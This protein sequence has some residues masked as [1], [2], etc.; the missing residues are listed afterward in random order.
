MTTILFRVRPAVL[1]IG[2]FLPGI[3]LAP[4]E[5]RA[6][7]FLFTTAGVSGPYEE[8]CSQTGTNSAACATSGTDPSNSATFGGSATARASFGDLSTFASGIANFMTTQSGTD[9]NSLSFISIPEPCT[10][11]LVGTGSL[12]L[13]A[14]RRT[15]R[16][17]TSILPTIRHENLS[18]ETV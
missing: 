15:F 4:T 8:A 7:S 2:I 17:L 1:L 3:S 5:V 10:L 14:L 18:R 16:E 9:Y 12:G 13:G 6:T 11:T